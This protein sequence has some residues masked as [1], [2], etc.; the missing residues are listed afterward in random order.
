[1]EPLRD[2]DHCGGP[3]AQ[4]ELQ[5]WQAKVTADHQPSCLGAQA[6]KATV[7]TAPPGA[8]ATGL[9]V[10]SFRSIRVRNHHQRSFL[11]TLLQ[12][13]RPEGHGERARPQG[14][15]STWLPQEKPLPF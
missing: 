10:G 15:E 2:A 12:A 11:G 6:S 1:M 13:R 3:T 4:E 14:G 8:V 9:A 5:A 7:R